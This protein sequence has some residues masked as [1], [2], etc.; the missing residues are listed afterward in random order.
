MEYKLFFSF[1]NNCTIFIVF[2]RGGKRVIQVGYG[3][4]Q[5]CVLVGFV[6][7]WGHIRSVRFRVI[8]GR[9]RPQQVIYIGFTISQ[10][11]KTHIRLMRVN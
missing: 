7:V 4:G 8:P 9:V 11:N 10:I 1:R 6:R 3:S 2:I 5:L